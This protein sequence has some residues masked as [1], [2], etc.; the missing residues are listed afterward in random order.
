MSIQEEQIIIYTDGGSRGNPGPSAAGFVLI[1]PSGVK[2]QARAVY[3]GR[4]TN[5]V[6][7]YTGLAKALEAA[8]G[9]GASRITAFSDSELLV[10]QINGDYRVKSEHIR[11]LFRQVVNMLNKFESWQVK[12][13][14]RQHNSQADSLVNRA[15]DMQQDIEVQLPANSNDKPIRLGILISGGG[16]TMMNILKCIRNGE[17]NTGIAVVISSR[18]TVA[19]VE[20]ARNA[21]LDVK[22]IRK[23]D[24]SDITQ[25]SEKIGQ[26]LKAA[27]V[28]LVVQAGWMCLWKIPARYE[29][30]VM[31]IHPA[32]L[33]SFGGKGMW[34]H[35]V[36][37]AVLKAGCKISG[38][39]VHFCTNEYDKGPIIIQRCCEIKND[40]T[41][42]TLAARVFEQECIAYPEAI[43]LFAQGKLLVKDRKVKI[44]N[45]ESSLESPATSN[46]L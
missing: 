10:K 39:T 43:K 7:E 27:D 5:N 2:I 33:P 31:N 11:V 30:R 44:V 3:L 26:A 9:L 29:N 37:E 34:G 4:A 35:Y 19:G 12:H 28:D 15:L 16:R 41:A 8:I 14:T 18:S 21:G 22:I 46:K 40:D 45:R 20:K 6:A 24:F 1:R 32:L 38:C 17:L 25:F 23:K 36:H 13:I 42:E